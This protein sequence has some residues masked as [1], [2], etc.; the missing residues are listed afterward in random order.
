MRIETIKWKRNGTG[1]LST[2]LRVISDDDELLYEN[3]VNLSK[4]KERNQFIKDILALPNVTTPESQIRSRIMSL[5]KDG[6][7]VELDDDAARSEQGR[8]PSPAQRLVARF[9]ARDPLLF[10]DQF[11]V[12]HVAI[13]EDGRRNIYRLQSREIQRKIAWG[14]YRETGAVPSRD[15]LDGA[16]RLLQGKAIFDGPRHQLHVRTAWH[17]GAIYYDLGDSRAVRVTYRGWEIDERPP[18]LFRR[19]PHQTVQVDPVS[20]GGVDEVLQLINL[21]SKSDRLLFTVDLVAGLVPGIS[22]AVSVFHGPQGSTKSTAMKLKRQLMDPSLVPIMGMPKDESTFAQWASHNHCVFLDNL[23]HL[24]QWLSDQLARFCTGDGFIKRTLFTDDEDFVSTSQGV[25]G[26][27]GINLVVTQPDLL[28]RSIMFRFERPADVDR[29]EDTEIWTTFEEMRPR[30]LGAMFDAL[31]HAIATRDRIE[32]PRLARL[33]DHARWMCA[34]ALAIGYSEAEFRTALEENTSMQHSEALDASPVANVLLDFMQDR[35]RWEG[36]P[37]DLFDALQA[38][39]ESNGIN[40]KTRSWPKRANYLTRRINEV[41]T[42]LAANGLR[43]HVD[44]KTRPKVA[45]VAWAGPR[46]TAIPGV[47]THSDEA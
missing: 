31:S 29:V 2:T 11:E 15:A 42:N 47:N 33:A 13:E 25:A 23:S 37:S 17:D 9:L 35:H 22:R 45:T 26:V 46:Q 39:A 5:L 20:G 19:F 44:L 43:F 8:E 38:Y 36:S 6:R 18:I 12:P 7:Q 16:I 28:D 10:H 14:Q 21:H 1:D 3:V 27:T 32:P 30:V 4:E 24:P 40:T 41:S 34:V